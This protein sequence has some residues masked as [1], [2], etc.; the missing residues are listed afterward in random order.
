MYILLGPTH[1]V[2]ILLSFNELFL[3]P[4][5][6]SLIVFINRVKIRVEIWCVAV[7]KKKPAVN[8]SDIHL[9][10]FTLPT[11]IY[12]ENDMLIIMHN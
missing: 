2:S 6:L 11:C 10:L 5:Q 1:L 3:H 7:K 9:I 8:G 4:N 12:T